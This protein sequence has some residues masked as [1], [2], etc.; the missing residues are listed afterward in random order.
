LSGGSELTST[1]LQNDYYQAQLQL[2][3]QD[4]WFNGNVSSALSGT[5]KYY[6]NNNFRYGGQLRV[7]LDLMESRFRLRPLVEVSYSDA[8]KSYTSGIPYYTPDQYFSQGIGLDFQY[9][10][11]DNFDYRTQ[12]TG[13]VMG[14]HERREGAFLAGRVQLEHKFRNFWEVTIGS[15][16]STSKV[17]RSNRVFFTISYYF[18]KTL[19]INK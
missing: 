6:T 5:G 2:Y 3:R 1:S 18:P 13:E 12:L 17:Y 7:Y 9:R 4:Y 15:E 11:P 10:K 19:S 8:A 16:I 14:R